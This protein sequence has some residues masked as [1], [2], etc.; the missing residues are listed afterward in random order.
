[1]APARQIFAEDFCAEWRREG[2]AVEIWLWGIADVATVSAA[3]SAMNQARDLAEREKA[4]EVR[5]DITGMEF[6]A[7][8]C[9]KY[10]VSWFVDVQGGATPPYRITMIWDPVNSWQKR[11]TDAL[12][13]LAPGVLTAIPGDGP[14]RTRPAAG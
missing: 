2:A 12:C 11:A 5:L 8:S 7:S 14:N 4:R 1:M 13:S 9:F 6:M 3:I 10:F